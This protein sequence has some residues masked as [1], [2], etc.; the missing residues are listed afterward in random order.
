M[1]P[2]Q[3]LLLRNIGPAILFL[4]VTGQP[5]ILL[6]MG[7]TYL[8]RLG[9]VYTPQECWAEKDAYESA[10][11]DM[12]CSIPKKPSSLRTAVAGILRKVWKR[13]K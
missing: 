6:L 5:Q 3:L 13:E 12:F 4:M 10:H 8:D 11:P 1:I 2:K 9:K 7:F